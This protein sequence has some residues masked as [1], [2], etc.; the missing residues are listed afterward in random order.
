VAYHN[1]Q[2]LRAWNGPAPTNDFGLDALF[3]ISD[4][5][6]P[7]P[8]ASKTVLATP[9]LT[10]DPPGSLL[11]QWVRGDHV[12]Q[13]EKATDPAGPYLPLGPILTDA[14]FTDAGGQTNAQGFYRVHQ[15]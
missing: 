4:I 14:T 13:L 3:V 12:F 9:S 8:S 2:L 11:L 7:A 15:W 5:S 1:Y 10:A 6:P